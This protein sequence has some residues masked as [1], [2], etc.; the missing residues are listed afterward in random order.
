MKPLIEKALEIV[1]SSKYEVPKLV[2]NAPTGYGKTISAPL[3]A[4]E[5]IKKETCYS[6]IH[7]L[8]FR[9]IVRDIYLCLL[10]KAFTNNYRCRDE[11][12]KR[13]EILNVVGKALKDVGIDINEI[14]YQMGEHLGI[15]DELGMSLRKEPLFDARYIITTLDSLVF[16]MFRIPVTEIYSYKKHYTIP[17]S[18]IYVSTLFLDEVHAIIEDFNEISRRKIFTTFK[19]MLEI[20]NSAKIPTI[21][22]SATIPSKL[23]KSIYDSLG[24]DVVL[25]E[26]GRSAEASRHNVVVSDKY[27]EASVLNIKWNTKIINDAEIIGKVKEKILSGRR[28]FVARDSIMKAVETYRELR[29]DL[30][31]DIAL[32]HSLLTMEDKEKVFSKIN[33]VKVL[34]ATSIVEAGV[35][36]SF[37]DLITDGGNPFSV[38]Q[39]T[40]RICRDLNCKEADIFIV[41]DT[42]SQEMLEFVNKFGERIS[43]KLPYNVDGIYSYRML[44]ENITL[45]EDIETKRLLRTL[46][47][48]LLIPQQDIE[49]ILLKSG[50]SLLRELLTTIVIGEPDEI[51]G[52]KYIELLK[53]SI[54]V[55]FERVKKLVLRDCILGPYIVFMKDSDEIIDVK[56]ADSDY[57]NVLRNSDSGKFLRWYI[58]VL[59]NAYK[60]Y[61]GLNITLTFLVDKKCYSNEGLVV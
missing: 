37:D 40:G 7:S 6:F 44:L 50:G 42:S 54:V 23:V 48:P 52:V 35:N 12:G 43:W 38:V 31:D 5:L 16:N 41:R 19:T 13:R 11:R 51:A 60:K 1:K 29:K 21:I 59:R 15:E 22:A 2:I 3:I 46:L 26:L 18:R 61:Q 55:D 33:R 9:A 8:P 14:A 28:V 10:L 53:K 49:N 34:V 25:V 36:I 45:S 39:R 58:K 32:I 56:L 24:D 17:W 4:S 47:Y 20:A 27:Y 57:E 30:G